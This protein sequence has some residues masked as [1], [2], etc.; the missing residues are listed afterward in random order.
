M[1]EWSELPGVCWGSADRNICIMLL[2]SAQTQ[3]IPSDVKAECMQTP[4]RQPEPLVP[5]EES[6]CLMFYHRGFG[7]VFISVLVCVRL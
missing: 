2:T 5:D 6:A 3:R 1:A 7:L 4:A